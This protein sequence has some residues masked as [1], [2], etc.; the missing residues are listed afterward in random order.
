M[1][2]RCQRILA[3]CC[4][5]LVKDSRDAGTAEH[6]A[7]E[8]DLSRTPE[9]RS[10]LHLLR[11]EFVAGFVRVAPASVLHFDPVAAD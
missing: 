1:G 7:G 11:E 9:M 3:A 2:G 8:K 10:A 6:S 4:S 5:E